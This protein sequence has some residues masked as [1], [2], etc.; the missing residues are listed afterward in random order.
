[1]LRNVRTTTFTTLAA[2]GLFTVATAKPLAAQ[3]P[4]VLTTTEAASHVG[5]IA[6]VC[7][8]VASATYARGRDRKSV[9]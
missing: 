2:L 8:E 4:P 7:G 1:M 9:V 3:E 5:E 6:T